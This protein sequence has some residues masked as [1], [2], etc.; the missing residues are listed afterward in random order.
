MLKHI[1][2]IFHF[3]FICITVRGG[4]VTLKVFRFHR[5]RFL[6]ERFTLVFGTN[7]CITNV[8]LSEEITE[9][10]VFPEEVSPLVTITNLLSILSHASGNEKN[11]VVIVPEQREEPLAKSILD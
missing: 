10:I 4:L 11:S 6:R 5:S 3:H 9:E 8:F 7:E 2:R 1:R